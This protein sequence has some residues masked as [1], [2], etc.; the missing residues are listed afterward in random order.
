MIVLKLTTTQLPFIVE[1]PAVQL[2]LISYEGAESASRANLLDTVYIHERVA[3][4]M[5]MSYEIGRGSIW[6]Y[7]SFSLSV[8][9]IMLP[10]LSLMSRWLRAT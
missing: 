1:S 4:V 9:L 10:K 3:E 8:K 2:S 6:Q 7:T 5:E